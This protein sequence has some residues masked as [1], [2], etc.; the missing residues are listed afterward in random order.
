M[1]GIELATMY[2]SISARTDGIPAAVSKVMPQVAKQGD[3]AGESLGSRIASGMGKTLAVG[4]AAAGAA[5]AGA[6]GV[7]LT[8]G[9]GRLTAIDNAE[10][11]LE[12][13]GHTSLSTAKIMESAL[14]SVKGTAFGLG[15]AATISASAVAAGI[16][17]GNDLTRYL[18]ITADAA[19]I[20]GTSIEEMGAVMN[21]VQTKGK[22]YTLDLNQLAIRGIPIYQMLAKEM[23]V[24]Q[25]ALSDMVAEGK[26]DSKT[27]LAAIEKNL[28]GA[29]R[30][31]NTVSA[32]WA[33]TMAAMGRIGAGAL[34]PTFA[35]TADWLKGVTAGI[36]TATPVITKFAEMVDQRI[37]NQGLPKLIEFGKKGKEAFDGFMSD[38]SGTIGNNWE[39]FKT[40]LSDIGDT[41]MKIGAPL[42][43]IGAS[44]SQAQAA[45]GVGTW[46]LFLGVLESVST[47]LNAT[48]VPVLNGLSSV[49][50]SNQVAVTGLLGAFMLFKTLPGIMARVAPSMGGLA[51]QAAAGATNM[52]AYQRALLATNNAATR[53]TT[54]IRGFGDQMKVQQALSRQMVSGTGQFGIGMGNAGHQVGRLSAAMGVLQ[55]Q[56]PSIGRMGEAYRNA[57]PSL[58]SYVAKQQAAGAAAKTAMLQSSNLERTVGLMGRQ[59]STAAT[60]GIAAMGRAASGV[61]AAGLSAMSSAAAGLGR[62]LGSVMSALGGPVGVGIMAAVLVVP[63][64]ISASKNWDAQAKISEKATDAVTESQRKMARAFTESKGAV[65][66]TVLSEATKQAEAY[67]QKLK[68]LDKDKPGLM[69][70]PVEGWKN[71]TGMFSGKGFTAGTDEADERKRKRE[72]AGDSL[73]TLKDLGVGAEEFGRALSG[74]SGQWH[75]FYDAALQS[76]KVSA[77]T[78]AEWHLART[79]LEMIQGAAKNVTPGLYEISDGFKVLGDE[80]STTS[81][82]ASAFKSIMDTIAGIPP[83]LG[84]AMSSYNQVIRE[85]KKLIEEPWDTSKGALGSALIGSNGMVDTATENGEAVRQMIQGIRTESINFVAAGGD[86]NEIVGKNAENFKLLAESVNWTDEQLA[87]VLAKEGY[88]EQ[89]LHAGAAL[90][91]LDDVTKGVGMV[92]LALDELEPGK[93][94]IIPMEL[95]NDQAVRDKLTELGVTIEKTPDGLNYKL[96]MDDQAS[97]KMADVIAKAQAV[98]ALKVQL[99]V[100]ADTT[101]FDLKADQTKSLI[102]LMS[103]LEAVPGADLNLDKFRGAKQIT[104]DELVDLSKKFANPQA[105]LEGLPKFLTDAGAAKAAVDAIKSKQV[106]IDVV[107]KVQNAGGEV[108]PWIA[109]IGQRSR[110]SRLPKNSYGSRLPTTGPGT[111]TVDGILGMGRDGVPTTWVDKGEWIVNGRSSEKW[112]WLLGMINRDDARLDNLPRFA[113]GGR[114][115]IE[116]ALSAGRGVEGNKYVWGGTGPSGFDCSGF[117]GWLQQIVM[118]IVGSTQRLY[119]TYDLVGKNA[120]AS[121]ISGLGPAGTQFQV[122]VSQD[123]MAATIA[124]Q[125]AESGGSFGTSGI[126]GGRAS[127]QSSHLPYKFHLPNEL[128]DGWDGVTGTFAAGETPVVWTEKDQLDLESARVAVTQAQEARDKVNTNDKKSQADKDQAD[129]KVQRAELKVKELEAK[130]EGRGSASAISNDPA[131][132]LT[133]EMGEDA[134]SVRN[135]EIALL[136]ANL[137]RDKTYN[138]PES[139]SLEKEKADISVYSAQNSLAQ[140]RKKS[141]ESASGDF[142]LKDRLKN[143]GSELVGIAVDSALEIFGINSRWLDIAIPSFKKPAEG[144]TVSPQSAMDVIKNPLANFAAPSPTQA[145]L[146][147]Q[148]PVVPG[149]GN[150]VEDW[151]KTLPIKLYDQGGMI[152]HGGLALN[153]S[154]APE[155]VFTAPEFANIARIANLDMLAINPNAG[156]GNDYSVNLHNPTFSDGMAAV[157]SAQKAQGRQIMRH[158]GRPGS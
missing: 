49:M 40:A 16:K 89:V 44:V 109:A 56:V 26:V 25:E 149:V 155:P 145:Q 92:K 157:R 52:S 72:E 150:W 38:N 141:E 23:G 4:A 67:I 47:I 73:A 68:E 62:G 63:Q 127:A 9:F 134:I 55:T 158:A 24:S 131:P 114:N 5:A 151:L 111:N 74:T 104:I 132:I 33:N 39:R 61:G 98:N 71:V 121:L 99:G 28:G 80:A 94:K 119:T 76:G 29:A 18:S 106:V 138:D 88:L 137:A 60:G 95:L 143:Y 78:A 115:G 66:D 12:G 129:L 58:A 43:A 147:G 42:L 85:A 126:G 34:K 122:G 153:K 117:V 86:V 31:G 144:S 11:K 120:F 81:Q 133:G 112:D 84:N 136:E 139:T 3:A 65:D 50:G 82:K 14:T 51:T 70:N 21:K 30:A 130:R 107:T 7:A 48:L 156:G 140:V 83:D 93:P 142:S 20:A 79:K 91:G 17:P 125:P 1:A 19:T 8:K 22:A 54:G 113:A 87:S 10:G 146:A 46:S 37:F 152:P 45:L 100:D 103:G 13:L 110:G 6:V 105:F 64:L 59:M 41:A 148:L 101:K 57:A 96:T 135:A 108:A 128:I 124:G 32:A 123:H 35:R 53:V 102:A 36:D 97:G 116:A 90:Q 75:Q 77:D 69:S 27:Y 2:V 154:G 118:G 15:E